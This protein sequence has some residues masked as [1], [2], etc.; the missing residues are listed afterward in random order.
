M[1]S[2]QYRERSIRKRFAS[3]WAAIPPS[4]TALSPGMGVFDPF[5]L[6][7]L[8]ADDLD[9]QIAEAQ[10]LAAAPLSSDDAEEAAFIYAVDLARAARLARD[11]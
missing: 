9:R 5:K 10:A 8:S 6:V 4:S 11:P 7:G 1:D 3:W 2:P